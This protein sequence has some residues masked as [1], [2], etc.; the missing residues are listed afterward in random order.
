MPMDCELIERTES[1]LK[2]AWPLEEEEARHIALNCIEVL[3]GS[4]G[5]RDILSRLMGVL[6]NDCQTT[7]A[8]TA[9]RMIG[10]HNVCQ[11]MREGEAQAA[12]SKNRQ[13]HPSW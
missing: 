5:Y 7:A 12:R 1:L 6:P 8:L 10:L 3:E 13:T 2:G 9:H 4:G 11:A